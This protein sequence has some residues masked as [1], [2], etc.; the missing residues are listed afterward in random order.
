MRH[1]YLLASTLLATALTSPAFA[2]N[3]TKEA[4]AQKAVS[5]TET[6][7]SHESPPAKSFSTGV[8]KGRDLL[9]TAISASTL[10]ETEIQKIGTRSISEVL[11]NMPGI[12]VV[13][14]GTD[15]VTAVTIRGLPLTDSGSKFLQIQEDGLPVLEFGDIHYGLTTAFLRT[16]LSL[17]QVQAI[18]GG[19]ASTFS[20]NSPGGIVNFISKTGEETGA[21]IRVTSGLDYDLGRV[22][23][24]YGARLNDTLRFNIGGYFRQG[25]GPRATGYIAFRGG[26]LKFN[27]TKQFDAGYIR[28]YAKFLDDKEPNYSFVPVQVSGTDTN[29]VYS[30]LPGFDA[31]SDLVYSRYRSGVPNLDKNNRV[32]LLDMQGGTRTKVASFGME[33]QFDIADWTFTNKMRYA[34]NSATYLETLPIAIAPAAFLPFGFGGVGFAYASG[35]NTGQTISN[36][37]TL[38]GNGLAALNFELNGDLD[39]LDSFTDDLRASRVWNV[40][41]GKLTTTGGLYA[42][43]QNVDFNNFFA[44]TLS[45]FASGGNT[46]LL[47]IIGPDGSPLTQDGVLFYD[48]APVIGAPPGAFRRR[49]DLNYRV[50]APYGSVNY[51]IGALAVGGSLRYDTGKVRGS[52]FGADLG[53]GRVGSAPVDMNGDGQIT[54]PEAAVA[55]L[56]LTRPGPVDYEY[57]YVSYSV[58]VNY[59]FAP[60]LSAF[61]R[62]SRGG[63]AAAERILFSPAVGSETGKLTDPAFGYNKVTQAEGGV[64]FRQD[65]VSVFVTGFWASTQDKNLQV[66]ANENGTPVLFQIDRSYSAKGVEL[67]GLFEHGPLALRL[68]ATYTSAKINDD[69]T[70]PALIG[71]T[72]R[73]QPKLIYQFTPQYHSELFTVGANVL[74]MTSSFTQDVNSLKQPGYTIVSPFL[75]VRPTSRIEVG[76]NAYNI[77]NKLALVNVSAPSL[78]AARG[79]ITNAQ[80]LTGRT[81]TA[82]VSLHF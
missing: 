77:F 24:N 5:H 6:D 66:A 59:R 7:K 50:L 20:S 72:P 41:S 1:W 68:G 73:Q 13:S 12:R 34:K 29:P 37:M 55:V 25:E 71:N 46:H 62:Y 58:G 33:A 36:P 8:A 48:V 10:D 21:T 52:I 2:E 47:D 57:N 14:G 9:D 67:E 28:F 78:A 54:P 60:S 82:S 64:K 32:G 19:S 45:D 22:D 43:S 39:N 31:R 75:Q 61:A 15:G 17:S 40:G 18:R 16:D 69:K 3:A 74:G 23:F 35:P 63:R 51:Q 65:G 81:I 79:G 42:S 44:V 53:N 70:T 56:P 4:G 38:N 11:G 30:S 27:V 49:T 26:Q 76:V 80:T